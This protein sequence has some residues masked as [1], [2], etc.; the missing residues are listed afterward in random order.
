[1]LC[2]IQVFH[3]GNYEECRLLRCYSMWFLWEPKFRKNVWPPSSAW[4]IQRA[5]KD[6][7]SVLQ[8]LVT[9][10]VSSSLSV[11]P[12]NGCEDFFPNICHQ[13]NTLCHIQDYCIPQCHTKSACLCRYFDIFYQSFTNCSTLIIIQ[14]P[15]WYNVPNSGHLIKITVTH[16]Q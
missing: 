11:Y 4:K 7:R 15:S 16:K 1:M 2:K 3:G 14:Y 5:K 13:K 9:A 12:H 8:L 6:V 10:N